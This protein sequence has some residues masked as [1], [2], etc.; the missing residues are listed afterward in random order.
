MGCTE[1]SIHG[2]VKS[3]VFL[4]INMAE[5]QNDLITSSVS[6]LMPNFYEICDPFYRIYGKVHLCLMYAGFVLSINM[7]ENGNFLQVHI[8][9]R[10]STK[11]LKLFVRYREQLIYGLKKISLYYK[12]KQLKIVLAQ[13]VSVEVFHIEFQ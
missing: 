1:K 3:R 7:I 13:H 10:I 11:S 6:F 2:P 5:N 9:C 8:S 4:C 12:A